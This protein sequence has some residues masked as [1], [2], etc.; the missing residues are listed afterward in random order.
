MFHVEFRQFPH[1]ARAFN[2]TREQLD[3]RLLEPWF[4]AGAVTLDDHRFTRERG[5]LKI[6]EA[7]ELGGEELGL[8]RGWATVTKAGTDVTDALLAAAEL[9]ALRDPVLEQLKDELADRL[10]SAPLS[11][12]DAVRVAARMSPDAA[13]STALARTEQ[14]V[15]E[16]LHAGAIDFTRSDQPVDRRDWQ[17]LLL[18]WETWAGPQATT[19]AIKRSRS[20]PEANK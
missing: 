9:Q 1:V 3:G 2:L 12:P 7:P 14:A 15:W 18:D 13:S 10:E 6:Y 17:E 19:F 4:G 8:G 20:S 5:K 16:L 11:L